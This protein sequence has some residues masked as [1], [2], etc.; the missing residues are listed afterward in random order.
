MA[1]R[2]C[3]ANLESDRTELIDL[4]RENLNISFEVGEARYDWLYL[5]SAH[6]QALVWKALDSSTGRIV[7]AGA[8]FPRT[9]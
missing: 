1:I 8:A 7:G 9:M 6:G 4:L 5:K 2:I 3:R